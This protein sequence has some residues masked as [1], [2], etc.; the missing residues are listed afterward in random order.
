MKDS[1][2]IP[3]IEVAFKYLKAKQR[4]SG[5]KAISIANPDRYTKE[6][7]ERARKVYEHWD[8]QMFTSKVREKSTKQGN[9]LFDF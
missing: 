1:S 9:N 6:E 7:T 5:M 8:S 3:N 2:R 4:Y